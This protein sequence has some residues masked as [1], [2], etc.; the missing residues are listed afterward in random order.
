[1]FSVQ[2][3]GSIRLREVFLLSVIIFSF[4]FLNAVALYG[5]AEGLLWLRDY[6]TDHR[7]H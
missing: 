7:P 1:M 3:P 6:I 2:P 5:A 4:T